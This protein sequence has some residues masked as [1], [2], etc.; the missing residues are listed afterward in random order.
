MYTE[1]REWG[2]RGAD[3]WARCVTVGGVG[4]LNIG[5]FVV[6]GRS[7]TVLIIFKIVIL[8]YLFYTS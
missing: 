2:K 7:Y 6:E 8:D 3:V 1:V 4:A 5:S